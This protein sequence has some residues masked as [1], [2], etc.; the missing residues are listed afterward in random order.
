MLQMRESRGMKHAIVSR[1][2]RA[3]ELQ[4]QVLQAGTKVPSTALGLIG[5]RSRIIDSSKTWPT[6]KSKVVFC[7]RRIHRCHRAWRPKWCCCTGGHGG[8]KCLRQGR[9]VNSR[10]GNRDLTE[11]WLHARITRAQ[12]WFKIRKDP[13]SIFQIIRLQIQIV[14]AR[15]RSFPYPNVAEKMLTLSSRWCE[16]QGCEN[17]LEVSTTSTASV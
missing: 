8:R 6:R 10:W 16:R 13:T 5:R 7:W 3:I 12:Q 17:Q 14:L 15:A 11:I 2:E 9:T 1:V 4:F